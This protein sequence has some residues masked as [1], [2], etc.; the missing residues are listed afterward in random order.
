M[1]TCSIC[2]IEKNNAEFKVK[3]NGCLAS[4]CKECSA[5]YQKQYQQKN[6]EIL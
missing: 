3:T 2:K 5:V 6:K 1:R 4:F